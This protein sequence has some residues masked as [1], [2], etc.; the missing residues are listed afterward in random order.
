MYFSIS[1]LPTELVVPGS[2]LGT[3]VPT[4][5]PMPPSNGPPPPSSL[6]LGP[7]TFSQPVCELRVWL[8]SS[9]PERKPLAKS[10]SSAPKPISRS[11]RHWDRAGALELRSRLSHLRLRRPLAVLACHLLARLQDELL[12]P[13]LTDP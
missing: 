12:H 6:S 5:P 10:F 2:T 1:P 11:L 4:S 8:A 7:R 3:L 9:T 13:L